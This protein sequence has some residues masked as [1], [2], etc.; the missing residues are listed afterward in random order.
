MHIGRKEYNP[1]LVKYSHCESKN[2]WPS[3]SQDEKEIG[4]PTWAINQH[5]DQEQEDNQD[6]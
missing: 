4:I 5:M 1:A 6:G 2:H 3:Y